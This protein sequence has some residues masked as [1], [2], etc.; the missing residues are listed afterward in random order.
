MHVP[1]AQ[2]EQQLV[3]CEF[4]VDAGH[5]QHVEREVPCGVPGVLPL[6]GHGDHVAVE[7]RGPVEVADRLARVG[8]RRLVRVAGE[9]VFDD[10]MVKLLAAEQTGARL[11]RN[12]ALLRREMLQF[13][14]HLGVELVGLG[15]AVGNR[16]VNVAAKHPHPGPLPEGEGVF[17]VRAKP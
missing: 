12:A 3:F 5:G 7:E 2:E 6:I 14:K 10:E 11:S 1:F 13:W 15:D 16:F 17:V 4:A 9:P 8:G